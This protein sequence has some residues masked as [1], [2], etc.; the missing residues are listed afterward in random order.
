[1]AKEKTATPTKNQPAAAPLTKVTL[2]KHG[3]GYFERKTRFKGPGEI[4][5]QC[6]HDEID[7]MLKSL[8]VLN[9]GGGRVS[10]VTYDSAKTLETRLAEFG[11]DLRSCAGLLDLIVQIKG[12][13]VTV[14]VGKDKIRGRVVGLDTNEVVCENRDRTAV[15]H[16]LVL[17]CNDLSLRRINLSSINDV[18]IDD[19]TLAGEIQQQLELLFQA[20][21]KKDR[22]L[23]K[24]ELLEETE[25]DL[26]I[27]YSI[28]TP[29]WKTSYRLVLTSEGKLLIQGMAI[30]DNTQEEDWNNVQVVLISAAPI[31]FIQPL[32]DPVQP[33]RRRIAAQGVISTGPFVAERAQQ[34][35]PAQ[36]AKARGRTDAPTMPGCAPPAA[37][38]EAG[39]A[40]M[41]CRDEQLSAFGGA[42]DSWG[43]A[44]GA[45]EGIAV[46]TQET[47][48]L[49]EYRI[50]APVTVPRNSSAL[51]PIVQEIIEGER[52]S[53]FNA[54][55]NYNYPYAAIRLVNTTGLTLEAGPVTIMEEEAY[56]GEAL[57]DVV[58][59]KDTRF[60]PYALDQGV[61]VVIRDDY[62]YRPVHRVRLW[63]GV[64]FMDSKQISSKTY[65]LENLS[66]KKKIV[67]VEHPYSSHLKLVSDVKPE[68][69]TENFYRFRIELEPQESYALKVKEETETTNQ[70]RL[71]AD[72][73]AWP[74]V[75]WLLKQNYSNSNF[76]EFVKELIVK[77]KQV[78]SLN[79][80]AKQL[81]ERLGQ[82]QK[83][84]ER[85][86][87]NV[88]TLGG[89]GERFKQAIEETEDKI[90]KASTDLEKL[91]KAIEQKRQ[92][93]SEFV[94]GEML[95]EV[96]DG[97]N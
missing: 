79:A 24:V 70:Y 7:D 75:D 65:N 25:R 68:E 95:S 86:R 20:A 87:E 54:S 82:H 36:A 53:L 15:E 23:L 81:K 30:V 18:S 26:I 33:P 66:Q 41:M 96:L 19:T 5:L 8:I 69:T 74:D 91:A 22:K 77:R 35:V 61:K 92:E 55:R 32:Y 51:I 28:P 83:D 60:L 13:P 64:L 12:A 27:A 72:G 88:K 10:A 93:I 17:Y 57:L 71:D 50:D 76:L 78:V 21:R 37:P 63:H 73:A 11:F 34:M 45:G 6:A 84:Q 31:S 46:Q 16:L 9:I 40:G 90:I 49:F 4:E 59:P 89:A 62:T 94:A 47:G 42:Y 67:F 44:S 3:M 52:L 80:E 2:Y 97:K 56:A 29:I 48:E 1:M 39:A 14:A 43:A 58:K 38:M 85:A